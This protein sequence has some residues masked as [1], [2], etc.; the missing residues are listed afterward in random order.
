MQTLHN[1]RGSYV[2]Q[3]AAQVD[4]SVNRNLVTVWSTIY[5]EGVRPFS[6]FFL[7]V[8]L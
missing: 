7:I 8:E 5:V 4:F 2:R 3:D 6:N 1:S